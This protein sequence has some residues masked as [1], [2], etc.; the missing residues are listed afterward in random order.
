MEHCTSILNAS[1]EMRKRATLYWILYYVTDTIVSILCR[2]SPLILIKT[3]K[4]TII[5][6][7]QMRNLG[8]EFG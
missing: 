7:F 2:L 5:I 1:I 6:S 3:S 8:T 4:G